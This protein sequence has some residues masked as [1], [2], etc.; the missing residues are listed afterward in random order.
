MVMGCMLLSSDPTGWSLVLREGC[1]V[2]KLAAI[3]TLETWTIGEVTVKVAVAVAHIQ[4]LVAKGLQCMVAAAART[5]ILM[6]L[7]DVSWRERMI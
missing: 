5:A 6:P 7:T 2:T 1:W 3:A 4:V